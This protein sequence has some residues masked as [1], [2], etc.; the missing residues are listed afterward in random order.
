MN[1]KIVKNPEFVFREDRNEAIVSRFSE[2]DDGNDQVYFINNTGRAIWEM[3]DGNNTLNDIV[4]KFAIHFPKV[5]VD[6]LRIDISTYINDMI[7]KRVLLTYE[8]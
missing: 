6:E 1:S 2:A 8:K 7:E 3:C 5:A 4:Q